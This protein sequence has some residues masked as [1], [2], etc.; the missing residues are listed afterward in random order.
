MKRGRA[1]APKKQP[2]AYAK[3]RRAAKQARVAAEEGDGD[4]EDDGD[5]EGETPPPRQAAQPPNSHSSSAKEQAR[6]HAGCFATSAAKRKPTRTKHDLFEAASPQKQKRQ[7][8]AASSPQRTASCPR[9]LLCRVR[10]MKNTVSSRMHHHKPLCDVAP[11]LPL[12]AHRPSCP[13]LHSS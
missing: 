11:P 7:R 12:P 8:F 9:C 6:S 5:G 4:D 10:L 1:C 13:P 3:V 2:S